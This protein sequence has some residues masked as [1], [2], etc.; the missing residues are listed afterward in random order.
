MIKKLKIIF[1]SI[2]AIALI[3]FISLFLTNYIFSNLLV[4]NYL[5]LYLFFSLASI[6]ILPTPLD[7]ICIDLIRLNPY[8]II[9]V[10]LGVF[11]GQNINYFFG[12]YFENII[13]PYV[14]KSTRRWIEK[15]L[16]K[17]ESYA[18]FFGNLAPIPY[19]VLNFTVGLTKFKYLKWLVLTFFALSL[20]F[21]II[22]FVFG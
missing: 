8:F 10:F 13:N 6:A 21:V 18:I 2:A 7:V 17:Y 3:I 4:P 11:T 9:P 1:S 15:H 22:L 14:K 20:K 19:T 12:R 5:S 16:F